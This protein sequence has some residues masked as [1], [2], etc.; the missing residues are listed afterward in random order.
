MSNGD[1][2]YLASQVNTTRSYTTHETDTTA[3]VVIICNVLRFRAENPCTFSGY[4]VN[5]VSNT[6][7]QRPL[8]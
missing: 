2:N 6:T 3:L 5:Q 7:R 8:V 1:V 4:S